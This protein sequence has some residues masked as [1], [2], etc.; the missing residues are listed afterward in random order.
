MAD[1]IAR[2]G[3]TTSTAFRLAEGEW[4]PDAN[5]VMWRPGGISGTV[6]DERGEPIVNIPVR[7][8]TRLPIAGTTQW[9]TGPLARTDDRGFYRISG[10][11][12]GTYI[13]N[14]PSVQST[15][16]PST[17]HAAVLGLSPAA[18]AG[19]TLPDV[20]GLEA[21]GTWL[22][23]GQYAVPPAGARRAYPALF[24][25]S[26]PTIADAAVID[27][28]AAEEER[29]IDFVM[30]PVPTV[31]IAGRVLG[32]S[33][34]VAN[35]VVR[36]L[37][38]G[39]ETMGAGSEQATA[40]VGTDGRFTMVGVPAG[41]YVLDARTQFA[42]INFDGTAH[43]P[44]TPGFVSQQSMDFLSWL[45]N[46]SLGAMFRSRH[47]DGSDAYAARVPMV[48]GPEDIRDVVLTLERGA[49][50]TGRILRDDGAPLPANVTIGTEPANGDPTLGSPGLFRQAAGRP[51]HDFRIAGL[52][53]GNYFLRVTAGNLRVKSIAAP[54]GDHTHRPIPAVPGTD[55]TG[56]VVTLTEQSAS[57]SGAVRDRQG[58][59]VRGGAVI[60]FSVDRAGWTNFGL[61]P[62]R[63]RSMPYFGSGGYQV[64]RLIAGEYFIIAVDSHLRDAWQDPRFFQTA[65]PLA[66]RIR[67]D[68]GASPAQDLVL[69]QVILR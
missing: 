3:F 35:L 25:P 29:G 21:D 58:A 40:L 15:V 6:V 10:L 53:R 9:A 28:K 61:V 38:E 57:V 13:V 24:Y 46:G 34:A 2:R 36:L 49:S 44:A 7:V 12:P 68:W 62:P 1:G 33:E 11:W 41:R 23:V 67:L 30:R 5:V 69:Q 14:V 26:T 31:R 47:L 4:I 42:E 52:Y 22:I 39:G 65:A 45:P 27:V 32:P 64:T 17:S 54:G 19:R 59:P 55:V 20:A 66:T 63:I 8:L 37:I 16:P 50:I 60:L 18:A 48:V 43:L 56:V 51:E